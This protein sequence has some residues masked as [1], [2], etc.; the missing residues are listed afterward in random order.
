MTK[1]IPAVLAIP[2]LAA[3]LIAAVPAIAEESAPKIVVTG[4]GEAA[5]S[6]DMAVLTLAV[7]R[8]GE[9]AREA[10]DANNEAMASVIA[11]MKEDGIEARDLQTGGLSINPRYIYPDE[12]N[13]EKSPRI[14]G[15][16]VSNALTVRI[17]DLDKVGTVLDRS[18]TLGV[19]QG[20]GLT[21]TNDD[22]S[23]T[24]TEARKRAVADAMDKAKTLAEASGVTLGKVMQISEQTFRQP[25]MPYAG[26]MLRAEAASD[27]VPVEAGENT[28]RVQV[29][30]TFG[31]DQ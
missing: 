21:F 15:Y 24:L 7:L 23:A 4:E 10:L 20:G 8:E 12:K 5:V 2:A 13:G 26:K 28:Y 11:A 19:N 9:T 29:T 17:R 18:V 22:P 6:P 25:P 16:E 1:S 31:L 14:V 27:A 3:S 30:V